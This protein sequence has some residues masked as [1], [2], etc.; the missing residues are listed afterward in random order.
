M[1]TV[2]LFTDIFHK[3]LS[4]FCNEYLSSHFFISLLRH[5]TAEILRRF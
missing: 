5:I 3:E 2:F 4:Q 1:R